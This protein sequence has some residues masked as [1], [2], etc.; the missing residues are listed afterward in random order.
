MKDIE[1]I[2]EGL[3]WYI[4]RIIKAINDEVDWHIA[5]FTEKDPKR[6]ALARYF[7]RRKEKENKKLI[8]EAC[9]RYR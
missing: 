9:E 6:R 2:R 4:G 1:W 8:K 3:L 5:S 7:L